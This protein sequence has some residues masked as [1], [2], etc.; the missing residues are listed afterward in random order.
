MSIYD[1]S[2]WPQTIKQDK[3]WDIVVNDK[4]IFIQIPKT[5]STSIV[6]ELKKVELTKNVKCYR[7]EGLKFIQHLYSNIKIPVYAIVRNPFRQTLSYF[8]HRVN[9]KE[10]VVNKKNI[11]IEFRKWCKESNLK[12]NTHLIQTKYLETNNNDIKNNLKIFKFED[13]ID[14][15]IK[16]LN[17]RHELNLDVSFHTNENKISEY[18]NIAF[19]DFFDKQTVDFIVKELNNQFETFKYSKDIQLA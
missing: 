9:Y 2:M 7:H 10:I 13:G 16:Y 19:L 4:F 12:E 17:S 14:F 18:K 1:D 5:G 3:C 6:S 11:I 15:F 8:F